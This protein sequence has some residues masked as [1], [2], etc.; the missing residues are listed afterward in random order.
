MP[1][2]RCVRINVAGEGRVGLALPVQYISSS[3]RSA[4]LPCVQPR[5]F[6][7]AANVRCVAKRVALKR[8]NGPEIGL[9]VCVLFRTV[10]IAHP[11]INAFKASVLNLVAIVA[12]RLARTPIH[13]E[14]GEPGHS[15]SASFD[16]SCCR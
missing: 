14:M 15:H 16:I 2:P 4:L 13:R 11:N 9:S 8:I 7:A 12:Q 10:V 5:G 3:L 1:F 6:D